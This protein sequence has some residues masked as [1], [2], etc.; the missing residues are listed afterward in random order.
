M[1]RTDAFFANEESIMAYTG[2]FKTEKNLAAKINGWLWLTTYLNAPPSRIATK[3]AT[4]SKHYRWVWWPVFIY[5]HQE[6]PTEPVT[7]GQIL[8]MSFDDAETEYSGSVGYIK[9]FTS[10][11]GFITRNQDLLIQPNWTVYFNAKNTDVAPGYQGYFKV[12]I[13]KRNSSNVDTLLC[14]AQYAPITTLYSG[15]GITLTLIPSGNITT[16]DRLRI[17]IAMG[18]QLPA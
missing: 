8:T 9:S 11:T 4:G 7:D 6:T 17:R 16:S 1:G 15:T 18:E 5:C 14:S 10:E 13:Y 3:Q 12:E 2:Y